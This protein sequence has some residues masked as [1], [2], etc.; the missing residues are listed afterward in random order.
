MMQRQPYGGFQKIDKEF[1]KEDILGIPE[2]SPTGYYF[3]VDLEYPESIKI[4]SK[5]FPYCPE[6]MFVKDE[7]LSPYQRKLL[8]KEKRL[9]VKK[10]VLTQKI[11]NTIILYT[12]DFY[13][14]I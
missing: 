6:S 7:E 4:Q 12:T 13:S 9:K 1:T 10:L 3:E 8:G 14:F 11:T 5:N 2:D